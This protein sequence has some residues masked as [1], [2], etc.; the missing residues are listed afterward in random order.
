MVCEDAVYYD[1]GFVSQGHNT[2]V[3]MYSYMLR[4]IF[5]IERTAKSVI[6][7]RDELAYE[8]G[9]FSIVISKERVANGYYIFIWEK[10]PAAEWR[11]KFDC[12]A[13]SS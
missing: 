12:N 1:E 7:V 10:Q 8:I 13:W 4:E 2:I 3:S 9:R 5:R 11:I 6:K